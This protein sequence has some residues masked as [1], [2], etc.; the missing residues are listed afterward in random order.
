MFKKAASAF[1]EHNWAS[2]LEVSEALNIRPKFGSINK[3]C[4]AMSRTIDILKKKI[5]E[6]EK[7]YGWM[8]ANCETKECKDMLV[9][10]LLQQFFNISA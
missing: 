5:L 2:L 3:V 6:E 4:S 8:F 1:R 7:K 10:K 9:R